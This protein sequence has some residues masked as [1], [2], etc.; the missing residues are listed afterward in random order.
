MG[1]DSLPGV[2]AAWPLGGTPL[3]V[4]A[5]VHQMFG[6]IDRTQRVYCSPS[7]TFRTCRLRFATSPLRASAC[8]AWNSHPR[9]AP[10]PL[11]VS[12]LGSLHRPD[13]PGAQFPG[14]ASPGSRAGVSEMLSPALSAPAPGEPSGGASGRGRGACPGPC[15]SPAPPW[16]APCPLPVPRGG[17]GSP[18]TARRALAGER[19]LPEG[20]GRAWGC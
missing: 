7:L 12:G 4:G 14:A 11:P 6:T 20:H 10:A 18:M 17:M 3:V 19:P 9:P 2:G 15:S 1:E 8:A 13:L 5:S 16:R